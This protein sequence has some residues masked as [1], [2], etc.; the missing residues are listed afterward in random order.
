MEMIGSDFKGVISEHIYDG[1]CSQALP[2][3]LQEHNWYQVNNSSCN[4]L[5]ASK[6]NTF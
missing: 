5:V 6:F 4:G 1:F 3:E 2:G